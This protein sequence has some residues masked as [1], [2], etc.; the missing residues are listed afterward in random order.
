M[1]TKIYI[2]VSS[3]RFYCIAST[4]HVHLFRGQRYQQPRRLTLGHSCIGCQ[5]FSRGKM[6]VRKIERQALVLPWWKQLTE[7]D[8][9]YPMAFVPSRVIPI[10]LW[11]SI[12]IGGIFYN[13][14]MV[15]LYQYLFNLFV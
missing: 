8:T 5:L 12:S 9:F 7:D 1:G 13:A 2:F 15:I 10:G 3:G 14:E 6:K 4:L 11:G